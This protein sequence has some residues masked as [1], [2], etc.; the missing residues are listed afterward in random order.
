MQATYGKGA[1]PASWP[2]MDINVH[3]Q[4]IGSFGGFEA[5]DD[6]HRVF[7]N[8]VLTVGTKSQ[9]WGSCMNLIHDMPMVHELG[10]E[11][12]TGTERQQ[13]LS[14]DS[15]TKFRSSVHEGAECNR[16]PDAQG[17]RKV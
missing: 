4:E 6:K 7:L 5:G 10:L 12:A 11:K 15:K 13:N 2:S 1:T 9:P 3:V 8:R 14:A 16:L 17:S